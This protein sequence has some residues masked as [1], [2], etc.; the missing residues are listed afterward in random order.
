VQIYPSN[1][2]IVVGLLVGK[3]SDTDAGAG[4]WVYLSATPQV[5]ADGQTL[6]L[7]DLA[8]LGEAADNIGASLGNPQFVDLV[9]EQATVNYQAEYQS[10]LDTVNQRLNRPLKNGFR[11]EGHLQSAKLDK[12][13][14]LPDGI[15]VALRASGDLKIVYGL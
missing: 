7:P 1:G 4:Q 9:K 14:L 3:T 5:E 11:M 15:A 10:L 8:A 12:I 2:K 13:L 6:K